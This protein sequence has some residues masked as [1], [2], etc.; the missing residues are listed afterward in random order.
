[1]GVV[2]HQRSLVIIA[3]QMVKN[4]GQMYICKFYT[5]TIYNKQLSPIHT[6]RGVWKKKGG[7]LA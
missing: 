6:T 7:L 2:I 3:A 4:S 5:L 1:M